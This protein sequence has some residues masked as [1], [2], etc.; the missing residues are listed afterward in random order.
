M[1]KSWCAIPRYSI[2]NGDC[3][4]LTISCGSWRLF[5]FLT[6]LKSRIS[7]ADDLRSGLVNY[8]DNLGSSSDSPPTFFLVVFHHPELRGG[9]QTK[10]V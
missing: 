2:W 3:P 7:D 4:R 10:Q 1:P 6:L 5:V 9:R 8:A